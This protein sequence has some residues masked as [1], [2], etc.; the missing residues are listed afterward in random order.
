[1][2]GGI[3][4]HP[5]LQAFA[6][7]GGYEDAAQS[8]GSLRGFPRGAVSS[9]PRSVSRRI[10]FSSS[11]GT[12]A[13]I[14]A[15]AAFF[16]IKPPPCP[17]PVRLRSSKSGV[18]GERNDRAVKGYACPGNRRNASPKKIEPF[19]G[20]SLQSHSCYTRAST[21]SRMFS[22][23]TSRISSI[24]RGA[25]AAAGTALRNLRTF[26]VIARRNSTFFRPAGVVRI[27]L[28]RCRLG[29][30]VRSVTG[31]GFFRLRRSRLSGRFGIRCGS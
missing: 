19:L 4:L 7:I 12:P 8:E 29:R 25:F 31:G 3:E 17:P 22:T 11:S 2:N 13:R 23:P 16:T 1:M 30:I 28:R 15:G 6:P 18:P 20:D 21:S 10:A 26:V 27:V 9:P 14:G 24:R 5:W